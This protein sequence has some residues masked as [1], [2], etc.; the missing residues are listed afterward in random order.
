ME[1]ARIE[2]K[3]LLIILLGVVAVEALAALAAASPASYPIVFIGMVRL[4][5]IALIILTVMSL[6]PGLSALGLSRT[7]IPAGLVQGLIWSAGFGLLSA[8]AGMTLLIAGYAPLDMIR[9]RIPQQTAAVVLLFLVGGLIGP[10]A[11]E[12]FFRGI[13]FGY[14]RRWGFWPALILSTALFS[15][16]HIN[17]GLAPTQVVGGLLFATAY[18][19]GGNLLV[20]ITL[21]VLGNLALFSLSIVFF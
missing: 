20:P 18:E 8:A 4:A 17:T 19:F 11:E 16:L 3:P 5:E 1:T 12:L 7:G 6:G 21:H 10:V 2:L 13:V 9:I 15:G 14:V